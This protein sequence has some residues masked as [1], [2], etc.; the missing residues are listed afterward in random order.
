MSLANKKYYGKFRG[1]VINNVDPMQIGRIQV[2]VPDV[3]IIP[4]TWAMPCFPVAGKQMG[5]FIMP[6]LGSGVWVEFEQGDADY[7]IW[8]GCFIGTVAELPTAALANN[9]ASPG[10]VLQT[11]MQNLITILDLPPAAPPAPVSGGIV[12]KSTTGAMLVVNDLGIFLDNGKGSSITMIG[13]TVT[14][15]KGAL[16]II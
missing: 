16:V 8:T 1:T 10:M 4:G 9:P 7:P 5:T 11:T 12:L 13:P 2:S 6:Q 15:N 3:S 14:I